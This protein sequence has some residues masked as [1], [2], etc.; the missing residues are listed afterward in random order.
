MSSAPLAGCLEYAG[1]PRARGSIGS[2]RK[3]ASHC[4]CQTAGAKIL[5]FKTA[6]NAVR[7]LLRVDYIVGAIHTRALVLA[8]RGSRRN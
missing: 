5:T 7:L 4:L 2:T 6:L 8:G 1:G 3:G